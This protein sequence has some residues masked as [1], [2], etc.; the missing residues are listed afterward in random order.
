MHSLNQYARPWL[1]L[2]EPTLVGGSITV[3]TWV[4][5]LLAA[6]ALVVLGGYGWRFRKAKERAGLADA[7]T[8]ALPFDRFFQSNPCEMWIVRLADK[9]ILDVNLRWEEGTGYTRAEA[10]GR[11]ALE[12]NLPVSLEVFDHLYEEIQQKGFVRGFELEYQGKSGERGYGLVCGER[13]DLDGEPCVLWANQDISARKQAEER[14]AKTFYATPISL[15]IISRRD[16]RIVETNPSTLQLTGL[17]LQ[18]MRGKSLRELNVG[19]SPAIWQEI[20]D[21]L[22]ATGKL[23]GY[24]FKVSYEGQDHVLLVSAE[25]I[26]FNGE[27]CILW[28]Q[29]D[30]TERKRVEERFTTAFFKNP[31]PMCISRFADNLHLAVNES[32]AQ[33][34][35]VPQAEL[36]GKTG[37]EL[38]FIFDPVASREF[39]NI[40][41]E[42]KSVRNFEIEITYRSGT[43]TMLVSAELLPL[44]GEL[45]ILWSLLDITARK[46]AEEALQASEARYRSLVEDQAEFVARWRP[47]GTRTF[48]NDSYCR[49]FEVTREEAL[50]VSWFPAAFNV[51]DR[52]EI[53]QLRALTPAQPLHQ[54]EHLTRRRNG[55]LTWTQWSNRAFFDEAGNIVEYQSVGRDITERKEAEEVLR[56]WHSVFS[57]TEFG[58]AHTNVADGTFLDANDAYARLRGYTREELIGQPV[59][60]IYPPEEQARIRQ[61]IEEIDHKGKLVF[62]TVHQRKDGTSMPVL[63]EITVIRDAQGHPVSRISYTSDITERKKAE[64]ELRASREQMRNLAARLQSIREEERTAVAREIHDELGQALTGIK[65]GLRWLEK[66]LPAGADTTQARLSSVYEL[67]GTT[68]QR[69]RQLATSLRPAVLDDFGLVAALEWQAREFETRTGIVCDLAELPPEDLDVPRDSATAIFR[70]FQETLTNVA[71]HAEATR[72]EARLGVQAVGNAAMLRLQIHDNGRGIT[73]DEI[74][75]TRSLGLVGMRE[76]ALLSGGTFDIHGAPG[77]GTV[78]IVQIPLDQ[79][80]HSAE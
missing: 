68:I 46:Q 25:H 2:A 70:I 52:T 17:T 35:G 48:V 19:I 16:Y 75:H 44:E 47:D 32:Y 5:L 77:K 41:F 22:T 20:S 10:L 73:P 38:G 13:F 71:R 79:L 39:R 37:K 34:T 3:W 23:S 66:G 40:L 57:Q 65:L 30:I 9:R 43:R 53:D 42:T 64:A 33:L 58:L 36:T 50:Q 1:W 74:A 7:I 76:R 12:L 62:E 15:T 49:F 6:L 60:M 14:F 27:P 56:R 4:A 63:M 51:I 18:E 26:E 54:V 59:F 28:S 80:S 72:V 61:L 24:E 8:K 45:S 67:I 11:T 69:V 55:Q 78:V 29:Q 21:H 31:T